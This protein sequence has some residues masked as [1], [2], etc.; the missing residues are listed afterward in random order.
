MNNQKDKLL[1][2][3]RFW[4]PIMKEHAVFIGIGLPCDEGKL[5]KKAQDYENSYDSLI[6]KVKCPNEQ[7]LDTIA[8]EALN[9]N[10]EFIQYLTFV[11]DS[12]IE[13]TLGGSLYPLLIDHMRREAIRFSVNIIKLRSKSTIIPTE[14]LIQ[15]ELFWSKIMVDH[16]E[17]IAHFL[18]P[19]EDKF[20]ND[21]HMFSD[22]FNR[23]HC[24]AE[25]FESMLEIT[26]RPIPSLIR[27][28]N[29]M[30][31]VGEDFRSFNIAICKLLNNCQILSIIPTQLAKHLLQEAERFLFEIKRDLNSLEYIKSPCDLYS[32]PMP[33]VFPPSNPSCPSCPSPNPSMPT[34]C[35][36]PIQ[37]MPHPSFPASSVPEA[38]ILKP[39]T[40]ETEN[41]LIVDAKKSE[42]ELI[43]PAQ[44][45]VRPKKNFFQPNTSQ[46]KI[47]FK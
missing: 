22:A 26:P 10:L 33:P 45:I 30:L 47:N 12:L 9:L 2:E 43:V 35:Y 1:D 36:P 3:L 24:Q 46:I 4:L 37:P 41:L 7:S 8:E 29:E 28:S 14:E 18:D 13:C 16:S 34:P 20:I 5:I 25:D 31:Q 42:I 40:P 21:A 23:L 38:P 39:S 17:F 32:A 6:K 19:S 44:P 11:L 27:F 15:K